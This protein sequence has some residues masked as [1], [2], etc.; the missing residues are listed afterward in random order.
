MPL[1]TNS[2]HAA[3]YSDKCSVKLVELLCQYG[4]FDINESTDS[5]ET[6]LLM[7]IER[8]DYDLA[9]YLLRQGALPDRPNHDECYPIHLACFN[10][11]ANIL[12]LLLAFN[13][14][15]EQS[16]ENYPHPLV[17]TT[18]KRDLECSKLLIESPKCSDRMVRE[19]LIE[20]IENGFDELTSEILNLRPHLIPDELKDKM[21]DTL[22]A[23]EQLNIDSSI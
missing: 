16:N 20:S 9:D 11:Q 7:A 23:L 22:L 8:N 18:Y 3:C 21:T 1:G 4:D 17:I 2:L 12:Y 6:P 14:T 5:G 19:I 15:I 10:G 13:A